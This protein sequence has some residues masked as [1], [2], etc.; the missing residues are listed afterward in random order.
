MA[1]STVGFTTERVKVGPT[2]LYL[3]KGG[4]GPPCLVLH[5]FEGHEGWLPFYDEL[6]PDA[7]VFAPSH[8]GY[9]HTEAPC[10][11]RPRHVH[12]LDPFALCWTPELPRRH[13]EEGE[14]PPSRLKLPR[15]RRGKT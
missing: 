8:P 15:D 3:L 12:L 4:E 10:A 7:T 2:Q 13:H 5:G 1:M 6:A 9:G 11:P 14:I